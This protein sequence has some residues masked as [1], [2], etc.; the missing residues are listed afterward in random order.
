VG[1]TGESE[2]AGVAYTGESRLTGIGYTEEFR[3]TC[4][5]YTSEFPSLLN[6]T[7]KIRRNLKSSSKTR[8][9]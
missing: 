4:I 6:N 9:I 5:A 8:R 3:L 2:L 1:Y 7:G